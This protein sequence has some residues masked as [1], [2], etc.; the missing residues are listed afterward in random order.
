[1]WGVRLELEISL[2]GNISINININEAANV[3][4]VFSPHEFRVPDFIFA[5]SSIGRRLHACSIEEG[6]RRLHGCFEEGPW[7]AMPRPLDGHCSGRYRRRAD[8]GILL[9][10]D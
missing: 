8:G 7:E 4:C 2:V 5:A 1:M 9:G 3:S 6:R 10:D